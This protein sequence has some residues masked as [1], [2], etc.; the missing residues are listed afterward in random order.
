MSICLSHLRISAM[1][2][3]CE[4]R[5]QRSHGWLS[6]APGALAPDQTDPAQPP[7]PICSWS[8][9]IN[10]PLGKP[11]WGLQQSRGPVTIISL[12][13]PHLNLG[14]FPR[15]PT[16]VLGL[17]FSISLRNKILT[18][19]NPLTIQN[20]SSDSSSS[21]QE[22]RMEPGRLGLS[23]V[24]FSPS[25]LVS[26]PR[27]VHCCEPFPLDLLPW[28]RQSGNRVLT[29]YLNHQSLWFLSNIICGFWELMLPAC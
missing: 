28:W 4:M 21:C 5:Q 13:L 25:S 20:M 8:D 11:R 18:N 26:P 17:K 27:P 7:P 10:R 23:E 29:S 9:I 12:T 19:C 15:S 1:V 3:T 24:K 6:R 22:F 14:F 2:L 16:S